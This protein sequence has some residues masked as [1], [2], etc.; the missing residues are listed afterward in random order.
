MTE[1]QYKEMQE[2]KKDMD[3]IQGL[4]EKLVELVDAH[5]KVIDQLKDQL[6]AERNWR[7]RE[8]QS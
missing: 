2:I 1:E 3:T 6:A 5:G 4:L 7:D 8:S